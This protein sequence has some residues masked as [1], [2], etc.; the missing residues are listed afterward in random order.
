[1]L[2][3]RTSTS[4]PSKH[5]G[6]MFPCNC[7][8]LHATGR[9]TEFAAGLSTD[10]PATLP[11][12]R[13]HAMQSCCGRIIFAKSSRRKAKVPRKGRTTSSS[14]LTCH[15]SLMT[16]TPRLI[17][18]PKS[19]SHEWFRVHISVVWPRTSTMS[20]TAY[21]NPAQQPTLERPARARR[22]SRGRGAPRM[23]RPRTAH[24]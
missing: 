5:E 21:D 17:G 7:S 8:T 18:C 15:I 23:T 24:V 19:D 6:P 13:T 20:Y 16:V 22:D 2:L 4:L 12:Q 11:T 1:M 10:E 9:S 14:T 3:L